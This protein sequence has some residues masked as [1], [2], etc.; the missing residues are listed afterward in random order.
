MNNDFL[1]TSEVI[2]QWFSRVTKSRVKIIGKSPHEWPKKSLFT[3]TNVSF[4]FLH[5]ILCSEHTIPLKTIIDRS[6]CHRRQELYF[7]F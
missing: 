5:A 7:L 3:E 4:Y 2:C 6:F 1:V